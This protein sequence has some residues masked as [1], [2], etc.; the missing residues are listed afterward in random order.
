MSVSNFSFQH[1]TRQLRFSTGFIGFLGVFFSFHFLNL[2]SP[3]HVM[4]N[5]KQNNL[6]HLPLGAR[7]N[8][9]KLIGL[10][11]FDT[12]PRVI[13]LNLNM[14][15]ANKNGKLSRFIDFEPDLDRWAL[16]HFYRRGI[17]YHWTFKT[18]KVSGIK[19]GE[20]SLQ[21]LAKRTSSTLA[22]SQLPLPT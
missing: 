18:L 7:K 13:W 14:K 8:H 1:I 21:Q 6:G 3:I 10:R 9:T 17:S 16:H 20:L 22:P 12:R 4:N 5:P 2:P 19:I 15:L 11:I